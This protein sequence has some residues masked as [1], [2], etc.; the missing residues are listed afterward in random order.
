[1]SSIMNDIQYTK[2]DMDAMG[3]SHVAAV[4]SPELLPTSAAVTEGLWLKDHEEQRINGREIQNTRCDSFPL[5]LHFFT[6]FSI[7][8]TLHVYCFMATT[9]T[10]L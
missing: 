2:A 3:T 6:L 4:Q 1:M 8:L 5:L 9:S 10:H 7:S